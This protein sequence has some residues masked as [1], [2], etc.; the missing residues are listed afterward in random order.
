MPVSS[1]LT[2]FRVPPVPPLPPLPPYDENGGD[3]VGHNGM[4]RVPLPPDRFKNRLIIAL[5]V[6]VFVNVAFYNQAAVWGKEVRAVFLRA[7]HQQTP[8][9]Q[10]ILVA[11]HAA[12]RPGGKTTYTPLAPLPSPPPVLAS[13][14]PSPS[15]LRER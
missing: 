5:C 6:S 11:P 8:P 14:S 4:R 13:P 7:I 12:T 15:P 3:D 10:I 2:S 1:P 9:A